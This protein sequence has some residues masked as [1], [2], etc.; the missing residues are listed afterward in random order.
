M[1]AF[2]LEECNQYADAESTAMRALSLEPADGWA[3][4]AAVHV[5]EMQGRIGEGM[6]FLRAREGDWAQADNGFAFHNW[7]HLALFHMDRGEAQ[8][9]L[10]IYDRVLADAH[11][12]ALPRVDATALLWRLMLEG[13]DVGSRMEKVADAWQSELAVEGGFYAFNDFHAALAFALTGRSAAI[14]DLR[15]RL[16]VSTREAGTNAEMARLVGIDTCEA[17]IA[18][19]EKRYAQALARLG[20]VRDGAWRFGGSHAQRDLLT[21]TL[22]EAA[23]RDGQ[24]PLARHYAQ[25][26]MVHK[27]ASAWGRRLM[28]R[29]DRVQ[30]NE[31][32]PA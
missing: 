26:R 29:I 27:P 4:H 3:V 30:R 9:A 5:M 15:A 22:I 20:A 28:Q 25:E 23:R 12:M 19:G 31:A 17:A 32:I 10:A 21:L 7:W 18:F 6:Q 2:G 14:R 16:E 24:L 8:A 11:A 13:A 1:H